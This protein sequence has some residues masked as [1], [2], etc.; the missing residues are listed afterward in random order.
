MKT[1][2]NKKNRFIDLKLPLGCL[3]M[4]YGIVL[5]IYGMI[6]DSA[7]YQKSLGVDINLDWGALM[8]LVGLI[9]IGAYYFSNR[10]ETIAMA[11]EIEK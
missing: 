4:F 2:T 8:L 9:L 5:G 7:F 3:L 11:V 6:T 1:T 10:K